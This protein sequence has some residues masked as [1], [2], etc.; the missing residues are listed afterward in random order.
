M[1]A[2]ANSSTV[3]YQISFGRYGVKQAC[4][5]NAYP[6]SSQPR[7]SGVV[8]LKVNVVVMLMHTLSLVTAEACGWNVKGRGGDR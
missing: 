4:G 8:N 1:A 7:A 6:L 2:A 5:P 3:Q